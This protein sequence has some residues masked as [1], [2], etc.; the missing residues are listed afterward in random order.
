[1]LIRFLDC[2]LSSRK[3]RFGQSFDIRLEAK[4]V[5]GGRLFFSLRFAQPRPSRGDVEFVKCFAPKRATGC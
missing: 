3:Q 1:M 4:K 2:F 5:A